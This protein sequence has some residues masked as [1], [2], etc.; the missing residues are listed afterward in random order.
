MEKQLSRF[1]RYKKTV[2]E[3]IFA[4]ARRNPNRISSAYG[5]KRFPSDLIEST[6]VPFNQV[7]W[8]G[9]HTHVLLEPKV[10]C[11]T[12]FTRFFEKILGETRDALDSD[13]KTRHFCDQRYPLRQFG[14]KNYTLWRGVHQ[15]GDTC[16]QAAQS[17]SQPISSFHDQKQFLATVLASSEGETPISHYFMITEGCI[18]EVNEVKTGFKSQEKKG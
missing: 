3:Q 4:K 17:C 16:C 13:S 11:S 18:Q 12:L 6:Q 9:L 7:E 2:G 14:I 1:R 5:N 10:R 8:H 15:L